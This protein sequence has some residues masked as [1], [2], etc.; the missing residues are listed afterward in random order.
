MTDIDIIYQDAHA[1]TQHHSMLDPSRIPSS[2]L[3]KKNLSLARGFVKMLANWCSLST[4]SMQQSPFVHDI[5]E[6]D[7]WSLYVEF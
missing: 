6:N 2:F 4:Y 7:V 1:I 5:L 3:I